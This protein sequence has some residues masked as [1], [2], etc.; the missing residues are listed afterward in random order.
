MGAPGPNALISGTRANART[1]ILAFALVQAGLLIWCEFGPI[2]RGAPHHSDVAIPEATATRLIAGEVPYRDYLVEYPP[3][4]LPF[5]GLARWLGGGGDGFARFFAGE[6]LLFHTATL[7][8]V[9]RSA[10]RGPA[11]PGLV[12]GLTWFVG[13]SV[14]LWPVLLTRYD[15]IPTFFAFA[16]LVAWQGRRPGLGG[17]CAG[18]GVLIKLF[19]GFALLPQITRDWRGIGSAGWRARVGLGLTVG[20][21][22]VAW[23]LV[24]GSGAWASIRY[25]ADRRIEIEAVFASLICCAAAIL[26]QAP[27]ILYNFGAYHLVGDLPDLFALLSLPLLGCALVIVASGVTRESG[28]ADL[29]RAS[30]GCLLAFVVTNKVL[31]PQYLIWLIPFVVTL[32]GRW[33][34]RVR[35]L[36][37]VCCVLTTLDY[38]YFFFGLVTLEPVP[39]VI[40]GARNLVLVVI[41]SAVWSPGSTPRTV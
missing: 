13:Y 22:M 35:G 2:G 33:A 4:A 10:A 9:G 3:L 40:V 11:A 26:G 16:A 8:L 23:F 31:S 34:G 24:G 6:V 5:F 39:I 18:L 20:L 15:P 1:I 21:G 14:A 30:L 28:D 25:H 7:W 37:A 19:P 41:T 29:A 12:A 32:Q 27:I 17:V 36:F 38:P